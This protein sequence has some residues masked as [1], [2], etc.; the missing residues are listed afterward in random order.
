MLDLHW[1]LDALPVGVWVGHVPSGQVAYVNPEFR[2][3]M[4]MDAVETSSIRDAPATYGIFDLEGRPYPVDRL[5]FSRVVMTGGAVT[6]D[7]LVIHRADGRTVNVR[8]FGY[9]LSTNGG[10][11]T[12]VLVAFIDITAEMTAEAERRHTESRLALVVNHAPIAVWA[13]DATGVVTVSEGAGLAS[14]GVKSGELVG[15]N[16]FDLY[17]DH[18]SVPGFLRRALAGESFSYT[19][20]EGDM[21]YEN[22]VAPLTDAA[23]RVTGVAGVFNDITALRKFQA[24]AIQNDRIIALGTLSASV[25]HE[26][27]NPLTYILGHLDF[28]GESLNQLDWITRQLAEPVRR[29]FSDLAD[30][31][32]ESLEPVRAGTEQIASITREL[33]TFSRPSIGMALVDAQA[34]VVSVLKLIGKELESRAEVNVNLGMTSPVRGD[35]AR[36]VQVILNLIVNAMQA[37]PDDRSRTNRISVSAADEGDAVVIEVTDNGPGVPP[38]DR[39]RIFEPFQTTKEVGDASGLGLFICRSIVN[40]WSGTVTV[41]DRPGGGARFRVVLPIARDIAA[42]PAPAVVEPATVAAD[43]RGHVMVVDD[44]L[45]V[46]NVLRAQL[47]AA[48]YRVTLEIDAERALERLTSASEEI[49]LVYCDLMMTGMSGMDFADALAA[50]APAYLDRVVFMTGGAFTARARDFRNRRAARC[51]DKPF[52]V[53]SETA[54]R[55]DGRRQD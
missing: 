47:E 10:D 34:V 21:I 6:V 52:D 29:E 33:R 8:A 14:L 42:P 28:L 4:G 7:D 35:P 43:A 41:D 51:V 36:L 27:N 50:R 38:E 2:K 12:H 24:N 49:E 31:M 55:L 45:P 54:S 26:I 44:E 13:A 15:K 11:L 19:V 5:P 3:I 40:A 18:P 46:A 30:V 1:V 37:L 25:A 9:P 48:G 22:W 39:E 32:R 17:K 20:Q 16:V 23:G 53:V